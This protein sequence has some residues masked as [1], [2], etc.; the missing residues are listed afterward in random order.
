MAEEQGMPQDLMCRT[1][2]VQQDDITV[3]SNGSSDSD[4]EI[5]REEPTN[6]YLVNKENFDNG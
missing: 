3:G 4:T 1:T 2:T 6:D 5:V